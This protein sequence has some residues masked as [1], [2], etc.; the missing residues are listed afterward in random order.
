MKGMKGRKRGALRGWIIDGSGSRAGRGWLCGCLLLLLPTLLNAQDTEQVL[1]DEVPSGAEAT[2][3]S[4][5][6][7]AAANLARTWNI[8]IV[9]IA[10]VRSTASA[11][12]SIQ[13]ET[14]RVRD[15]VNSIYQE[16]LNDLQGER[17]LLIDRESE[18]TAQEFQAAIANLERRAVDLESKRRQNFS[19]LERRR[20]EASNVADTQL[21][22]VLAGLLRQLQASYILNQQSALV[23]PDA[24]N[25]TDQAIERLNKLLPSVSF[26]ANFDPEGS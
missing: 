1:L 3:E 26:N 7:E 24:A 25:V 16:R 13:Q 14:E 9:D 18:L 12:Q 5:N 2:A 6:L 19:N 23:W 21:N 4:D 20:Q 10:R 22:A 17:D 15:L 11:Y 8:L